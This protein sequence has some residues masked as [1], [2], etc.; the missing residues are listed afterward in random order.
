M[1]FSVLSSLSW[2]LCINVC[3]PG[4]RSDDG[5]PGEAPAA[6]RGVDAPG[7]GGAAPHSQW[8]G[9]GGERAA[10][11]RDSFSSFFQRFGESFRHMV[12][13]FSLIFYINEFVA[14]DFCVYVGSVPPFWS[15]LSE[16]TDGLGLHHCCYGY[17]WQSYPASK[18]ET[19]D[20]KLRTMTQTFS[21]WLVL[22]S[23]M[24]RL[25]AVNTK[26]R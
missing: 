2:R 6:A 13:I 1:S 4:Q 21:S 18:S 14:L 9:G 25:P 3:R 10:A 20:L 22:I 26:R 11:S 17:T 8:G 19:W 23:H 15:L 16:I 24:T 7:P 5:V 12:Q